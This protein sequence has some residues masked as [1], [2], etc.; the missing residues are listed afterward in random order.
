MAAGTDDAFTLFELLAI[1]AYPCELFREEL[2]SSLRDLFAP[3]LVIVD[4]LAKHGRT[5]RQWYSAHHRSKV[6][7]SG[8]AD[9]SN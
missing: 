9:L 3:I 4:Q 7:P 6:F 1:K 8:T 2:L 5:L